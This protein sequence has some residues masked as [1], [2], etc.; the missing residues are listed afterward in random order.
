MALAVGAP[1]ADGVPHGVE[2]LFVR[3]G[4]T[5]HKA[6]KTAHI[7]ILQFWD[8][9]VAFAHFLRIKPPGGNVNCRERI[10]VENCP[11]LWYD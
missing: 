8:Q 7:K 11:R 5:G 2:R 3:G 9:V 1:V 4:G 6:G 10:G